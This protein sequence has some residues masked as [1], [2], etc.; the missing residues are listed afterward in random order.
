MVKKKLLDRVDQTNYVT[1]P[2]GPATA[3]DVLAAV[4][5]E[6][7]RSRY[8][9]S[10]ADS[11]PRTPADVAR[12]WPTL[13]ERPCE[14]TERAQKMA[15]KDGS[16]V[17]WK[18]PYIDRIKFTLE[19]FLRLDSEFQELIIAAAEEKI[20]W[21]GED[22]KFFL[23]VIRENDKMMADQNYKKNVFRSM[24]SALIRRLT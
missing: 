9:H 1:E 12:W 23:G 3:N 5:A 16:G 14:I 24:R 21:R 20:F 22:R 10:A 13:Q 4:T 2:N 11:I 17:F 7:M 19:K 15:K 6:W 18:T 8:Y